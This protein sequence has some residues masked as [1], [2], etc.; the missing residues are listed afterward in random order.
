MSLD[1]PVLITTADLQEIA[2]EAADRAVRKA[3]EAGIG[4]APAGCAQPTCTPVVRMT[5]IAVLQELGLAD[6][7]G[8]IGGARDDI[9]DLRDLMQTL[10]MVKRRV[11]ALI[12]VIIFALLTPLIITHLKAWWL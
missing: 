1:K 8:R 3:Q 12:I 9:V 5:V 10:R 7:E 4:A 2:R 6:E 11:R